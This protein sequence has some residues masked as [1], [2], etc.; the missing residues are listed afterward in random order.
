MLRI[1][2]I[3]WFYKRK[4]KEPGEWDNKFRL[5]CLILL[6]ILLIVVYTIVGNQ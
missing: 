1:Q 6:V 4:Y 5:L 3:N 2:K